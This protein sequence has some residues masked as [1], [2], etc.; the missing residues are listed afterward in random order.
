MFDFVKIFG[1]SSSSSLSSS[2]EGNNRIFSSGR[3]VSTIYTVRKIL[4]RFN[5]MI[6]CLLSKLKSF[7]KLYQLF[8]WCHSDTCYSQRLPRLFISWFV[9]LIFSFWEILTHI[10]NCL[11][12]L[13]TGWITIFADELFECVWPFCGVGD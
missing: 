3:I 2:W 5:S 4:F 12:L 11:Y 13:K 8:S 9:T 1:R 7:S 6:N 10:C